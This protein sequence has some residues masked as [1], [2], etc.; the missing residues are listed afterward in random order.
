MATAKSDGNKT[1][2]PSHDQKPLREDFT[3]RPPAQDG[4]RKSDNTVRNT[5][6]PP[7]TDKT[8]K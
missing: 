2:S 8:K 4:V 3:R 5:I 1:P 6:P 7:E